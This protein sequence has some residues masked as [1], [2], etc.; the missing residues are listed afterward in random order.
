MIAFRVE[1]WCDG[2]GEHFGLGVPFQSVTEA[3]TRI[4]SLSECA[5]A[6]GWAR[7]GAA[8]FCRNCQIKRAAGPIIDCL[9]IDEP[10]REGVEVQ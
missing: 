5:V 2:C 7:D 1:I 6:A 4:E 3:V 9:A 8:H 10:R